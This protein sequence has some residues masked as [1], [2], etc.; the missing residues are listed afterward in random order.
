VVLGG[1]A[2]GDIGKNAVLPALML[3]C[4][5]PAEKPC[6]GPAGF[7]SYSSVQAH[8]SSSGTVSCSDGETYFFLLVSPGL[9]RLDLSILHGMSH[10]RPESLDPALDQGK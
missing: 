9:P 10:G 5:Q 6:L 1:Y 3:G 8:R 2:Q 7:A 4:L